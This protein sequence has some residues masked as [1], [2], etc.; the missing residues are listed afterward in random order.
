MILSLFLALFVWLITLWITKQYKSLFLCEQIVLWFVSWLSYAVLILFLQWIIFNT[1][2]LLPMYVTAIALFIYSIYLHITK[3]FYRDVYKHIASGIHANIKAFSWLYLWKKVLLIMIILYSVWKVI[4]V[5]G[6]NTSMPTYDED[7]VAWWDMKTKVF[8][9]QRSLVLDTKS[10]EFLWTDLSRYPFAWLV[11]TYL[12]LPLHQDDVAWLTNIISPI[13]YLLSILLLFWIFLRLTDMF[14][15]V[16]MAYVFV[17]MPFLF[18]HAIWS[19]RNFISWFLLFI[20]VFYTIDQYIDKKNIAMLWSI[21]PIWILLWV[22]R[23]EAISLLVITTL[24]LIIYSYITTKKPFSL[25]NILL[26]IVPIVSFWLTKYIVSLYPS[27]VDLNTWG[28]QV[29][30]W[31]LSTAFENIA[32][33]WVFAAPFAQAFLHPDYNL[34][35]IL[36]VV[37]LIRTIAQIKKL[38]Y[39]VPFFVITLVLLWV[40][41]ITLYGNVE[42]LWL[43]THFAFVRYPLW[44]IHLLIFVTWYSLYSLNKKF[45][46]W[47]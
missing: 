45:T 10:N 25:Q 44:I 9:E 40:F 38:R 12:L 36:F 3:W 26:L 4:M 17:S 30:L 28:T 23:N 29:W 31:L 24:L 20:L 11:D 47:K 34:F 41:M 5:F 1:I 7:A 42:W 39:I 22:I 8:Y 6:I 27:A 14:F 2:S 33:P 32:K 37:A 43:L 15:A 19:Y 16:I 18:I 46:T 35:F 13:V 21:V